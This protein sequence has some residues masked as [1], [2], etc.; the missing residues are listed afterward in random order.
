MDE[1]KQ[2]EELENNMPE[3]INQQEENTPELRRTGESLAQEENVE[4]VN[5]EEPKEEKSKDKKPNKKRRIS[6]ITLAI[7]ILV[8][9]A[10]VLAIVFLRP[11]D[12][13]ENNTTESQ[14]NTELEKYCIS[15]N[16]INDFDLRF[17]QL[18]SGNKNII[19]SPLSIKYC[20]GM[21]NEGAAGET[22]EQI[23]K[24]IGTYSSKKYVNSANMSFANAAFIRESEKDNI[25]ETY[26]NALKEKYDAD[27]RTDTFESASNMNS[28][29]SE[30]TLNLI[31]NTLSD[32]TVQNTPS[33]FFLINALAID[34]DWHQKFLNYGSVRYSH[35]N[36]PGIYY[37]PELYKNTFENVDY[38]VSGMYIT[39]VFNNYD[40]V[41]TI[42]EDN[43]RKTVGDAYRAYQNKYYSDEKTSEEIESEVNRYLGQ[44]INEISQNYLKNGYNTE[45]SLYVDDNVDVFAKDLKA[46][47]G[48]QLQYVG[49][50][51]KNEDLATYINKVNAED[52]KNIVSNLKPLVSSSF[53]DGVITEIYGFI[54]KFK[55]EYQLDLE[56]DIKNMG[57]TDIFDLEKSQLTEITG[58]VEPVNELIHKANIEFTQ[59]G[60]KAA[61]VT[62]VGGGGGG[63]GAFD[64]IYEVPVET[65]ELNFNKPY[66]YLIRDKESGEI[67]FVGSVYNPMNVDE[68]PNGVPDYYQYSNRV[69]NRGTITVGEHDPGKMS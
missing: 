23:T 16:D 11:K 55:Y 49:I 65:I 45:F 44:Y 56:N 30:R 5:E 38:Q 20:L 50:M 52:L 43:V 63:G 3:E 31:N 22:K 7:L 34:M 37:N 12:E 39:A 4:K 59:D 54:P 62:V 28:W 17:L 25:K 53:K 36:Y 24:V 29:I 2:V 67:W 18:E 27:V 58:Q 32:E 19:Y 14:T 1:E 41:G 51:P 8:A 69:T 15:G 60:I 21:L 64:Y 35:I 33:N 61:A 48:N 66:M 40:L 68:E 57:I 9:I 42:G 6:I 26:T 47:N 46:Y 13:V 10:L